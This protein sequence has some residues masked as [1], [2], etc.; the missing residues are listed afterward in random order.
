MLIRMYCIISFNSYQ[1][2]RE[3]EILLE[4][5]MPY[6]EYDIDVAV[7]N[8]YTRFNNP[9]LDFHQAQMNRTLEGGR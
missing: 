3:H 4:N 9:V 8:R 6:T 7:S 5:L 2:T 1:N